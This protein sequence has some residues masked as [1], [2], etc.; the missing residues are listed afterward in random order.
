MAQDYQNGKVVN[1]DRR[2]DKAM[3]IIHH[4]ATLIAQPEEGTAVI[5]IRFSNKVPS[6]TTVHMDTAN[7]VTPL[8]AVE[9]AIN[10]LKAELSDLAA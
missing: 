6:K 8:K 7:D 10:I 1:Q 2:D 4:A 5:T 3:D 9:D